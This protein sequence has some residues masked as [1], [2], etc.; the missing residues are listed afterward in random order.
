V[1]FLE[2]NIS[3]SCLVKAQGQFYF[4]F[5]FAAINIGLWPIRLEFDPTA[6]HV[7]MLWAKWH[8]DRL[9]PESLISPRQINISLMLLRT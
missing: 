1:S 9:S 3:L 6:V 5:F 4:T 2:G 7:D 8:M